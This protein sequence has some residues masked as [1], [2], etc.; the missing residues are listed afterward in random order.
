MVLAIPSDQPDLD[1]KRPLSGPFAFGKEKWR[2]QHLPSPSFLALYPLEYVHHAESARE[3]KSYVK[4]RC[5]DQIHTEGQS[6]I[7][8][9]RNIRNLILKSRH[10]LDAESHPK[11]VANEESHRNK[12]TYRDRH[13][14]RS[15]NLDIIDLILEA[16]ITT[17]S[18]TFA[19]CMENIKT[20]I[21]NDVEITHAELES[22]TVDSTKVETDSDS[23]FLRSSARISSCKRHCHNRDQYKKYS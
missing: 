20:D 23:A 8:K 22:K 4:L 7:E 1:R 21:C 16:Y 6:Q 2:Q 17:K 3:A 5:K 19:S 10:R 15:V 11:R 14:V 9:N 12:E 13:V 18:K